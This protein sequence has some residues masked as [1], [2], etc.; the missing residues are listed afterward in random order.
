MKFM[1]TDIID[2]L[3]NYIFAANNIVTTENAVNEPITNLNIGGNSYQKVV[4]ASSESVKFESDNGSIN[5]ANPKL[6]AELDI[7]G[8]SYQ[9]TT[10]R[11]QLFNWDG[12]S[13]PTIATYENGVATLTWTS[14]FDVFFL[15]GGY[16]FLFRIC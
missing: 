9:E 5:N 1:A 3:P 8:N 15:N 14:G 12:V 13:N 16:H 10:S 7:E 6:G 4:Q 11:Y 2:T